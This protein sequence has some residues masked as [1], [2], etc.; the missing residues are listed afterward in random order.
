MIVNR[1]RFNDVE[2][3]IVLWKLPLLR[4]VNLR[5]LLRLIL[6]LLFW[7]RYEV[8]LHFAHKLWVRR[9]RFL[10]LLSAYWWCHWGHERVL[11]LRL[12]RLL[13]LVD[14]CCLCIRAHQVLI[15]FSFSQ[16]LFCFLTKTGILLVHIYILGSLNLLFP[17]AW[18]LEV[19]VGNVYLYTFYIFP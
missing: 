12:Y 2:W 6:E 4:H 17:I 13:T 19:I 14:I 11:F 9:F 3:F 16:K 18:I 8:A 15:L 10:D 1:L 5:T 7:R